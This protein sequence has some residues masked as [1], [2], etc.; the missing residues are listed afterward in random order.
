M[1]VPT[2]DPTPAPHEQDL[3]QQA[4]EGARRLVAELAR[5]EADL[6][7]Q[8]PGN[9]APWARDGPALARRALDA[10][11]RLLETLDSAAR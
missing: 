2:D 10:A 7:R 8:R 5:H 11:R 1:P 4:G 9:P 6:A 3:L